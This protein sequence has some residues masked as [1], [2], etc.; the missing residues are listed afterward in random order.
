MKPF[1]IDAHCHL[2][3]E[4]L[5]S[6]YLQEIEKAVHLNIR[7]FFSTALST[8]EI[9]RHLSQK[10]PLVNFVAGIH[11][12]Y[13]T[14]TPLSI[15]Y[16][17]NLASQG[18]LAGIGEI[19]LDKRADDDDYQ[20]AVL[21]EQL[22]IANDFHL[23]VVFHIVGRY[24]ELL[25][26][27]KDH[28]PGIRGIIHGFNGS[29]EIVK[30][31][32]GMNIGFSLGERIIKQRKAAETLEAILDN[33]FYMFETDAPYQKELDESRPDYLVSLMNTVGKVSDLTSVS[34]DELLKGQ[35]DGAKKLFPKLLTG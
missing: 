6:V 21:S 35:W 3:N 25:R 23:P 28:F 32:S 29:P 13:E 10:Y 16:I 2:C 14:C 9:D 27:L 15:S 18:L 12:Y 33:G 4:P 26:L 24:Y 1:W 5:S 7:A 11:P 20:I 30:S 31:F 8:A 19:G 17:R 22:Q 34:Y